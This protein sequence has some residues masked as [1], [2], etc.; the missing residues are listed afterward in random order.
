MV[1]MCENVIIS[2]HN[3]DE[4]L[5]AQEMGVY[6]VTYS[7][8][9]A[10]PEK[11]EPKGAGELARLCNRAG[12]RVFALGGIVTHEQISLVDTTK[13]YGFASIRYFH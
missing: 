11:G 3:E 7:P 2:T 12:V 4:V 5:R 13:A 6:A 9:F 8:I 1:M 10:T